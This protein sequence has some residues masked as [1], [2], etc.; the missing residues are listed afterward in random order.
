[1]EF[2]SHP[3][4]ANGPAVDVL[5]FEEFGVGEFEDRVGAAGRGAG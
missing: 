4:G 5:D 2:A 3:G 1:V